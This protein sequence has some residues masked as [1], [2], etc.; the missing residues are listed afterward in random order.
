MNAAFMQRADY[1]PSTLY[2][3]VLQRASLDNTSGDMPRGC[4]FGY[5]FTGAITDAA[6]SG[7]SKNA[8]NTNNSY[9]RHR[10]NDNDNGESPLP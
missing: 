2:I 7:M 1:D 10:G 5:I 4:Q 6:G 3:F 9:V 8:R